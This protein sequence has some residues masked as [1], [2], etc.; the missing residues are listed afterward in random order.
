MSETSKP[1]SRQWAQQLRLREEGK[2]IVCWKQLV[3]ETTYCHTCRE[4]KNEY[5]RRIKGYSPW[6]PG[7]RGRPQRAFYQGSDLYLSPIEMKMSRVDWS[8]S[9]AE[10]AEL[11][12]VTAATVKKYRKLFGGEHQESRIQKLTAPKMKRKR[13]KTPSEFWEKH[14][15]YK[16]LLKSIDWRL[17]SREISSLT[18]VP[19]RTVNNYRKK[20]APE[21][22]SSESRQLASKYAKSPLGSPGRLR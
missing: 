21:T 4:K 9:N 13:T 5:A 1:I 16:R 2:C 19:H 20:Y 18:K 14:L 6:V 7:K 8:L 15:M 22:L 3:L 10:I 11:I 12:F 17:T